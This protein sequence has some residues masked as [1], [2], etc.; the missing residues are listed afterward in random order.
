MYHKVTYTWHLSHRKQNKL[1]QI[2]YGNPP[3]PKKRS[4]SLDLKPKKVKII[5]NKLKYGEFDKLR[6]DK[7]I[8]ENIKYISCLNINGFTKHV[9]KSEKSKK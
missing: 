5:T 3:K 6:M 2:L 1:I 7:V 8:E 9:K 4:C